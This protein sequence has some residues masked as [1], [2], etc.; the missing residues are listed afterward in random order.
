[1]LKYVAWVVF[2]ILLTAVVFMV[3]HFL[4]AVRADEYALRA[5][6]EVRA[7][8]EEREE[9]KHQRQLEMQDIPAS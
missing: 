3:W 1:M 6:I 4:K 2:V 8:I 9:R 7:L 5:G